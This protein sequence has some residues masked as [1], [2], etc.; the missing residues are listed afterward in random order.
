MTHQP[1][2]PS[3]IA[4]HPAAMCGKHPDRR[5]S[6]TCPYCGSFACSECTVDTLWG[7]VMC[8]SCLSRGRAEY[9][10]PWERALNPLAFFRTAY[11]VITDARLLFGHFPRGDVA[12]AVLFSL[13]LGSLSGALATVI[14]LL[15][16]RHWSEAGPDLIGFLIVFG[17]ELLWTL[18]FV[19]G[20][21]ATFH[22]AARLLG[23]KARFNVSFRA[24]CYVSVLQIF[25]IVAALLDMILIGL[26][27]VTVVVRLVQVFFLV[28]DMSLVGQ[29]RHALPRGRALAAGF[30]PV[31]TFLVLPIV[32]IGLWTILK[33]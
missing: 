29:F 13:T 23:G 30:A 24:A 5:A 28:W 16:P 2:E 14:W 4:A 8:G 6:I 21:S 20:V 3:S 22:A 26:S 33:N 25:N 7:E 1:A 11:L 32:L 12:R 17:Q 10:L 19:I 18:L 9:P 31:V 15:T 27:P